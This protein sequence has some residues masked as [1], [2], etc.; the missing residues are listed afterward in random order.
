MHHPLK[1]LSQT[2]MPPN[3]NCKFWWQWLPQQDNAPWVMQTAHEWSED[4]NEDPIM[5]TWPHKFSRICRCNLL[6]GVLLPFGLQW[7][8]VVVPVMWT[9]VFPAEYEVTRDR[10]ESSLGKLVQQRWWKMRWFFVVLLCFIAYISFTLHREPQYLPWALPWVGQI[11]VKVL[12]RHRVVF[13]LL[14][15][16]GGAKHAKREGC[17]CAAE[18]VKLDSGVGV[19]TFYLLCNWA[20]SLFS[21][22]EFKCR[23]K[24]FTGY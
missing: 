14:W 17:K 10:L 16:K 13:I 8:C 11:N 2:E 12:E 22:C 3:V 15:W 6:R 19:L 4:C 1:T 23:N 18:R 9:R 7:C 24:G 20:C 21:S 5:S